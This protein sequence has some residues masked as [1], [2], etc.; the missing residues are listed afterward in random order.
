[1][2][3]ELSIVWLAVAERLSRELKTTSDLLREI[4]EVAASEAKPASLGR[5][6]DAKRR[7][8]GRRAGIARA[9]LRELFARFVGA[10]LRE[11]TFWVLAGFVGAVV[12]SRA[13]VAFILRFGLQQQ[14]F[15]LRDSG[16]RTPSTCTISTTGSRSSS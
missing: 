2:V 9:A 8:V 4:R 6:L 12:V 1:V 3:A 16:G 11:P 14:L 15:N 13:V 7:Q 5:L 10:H